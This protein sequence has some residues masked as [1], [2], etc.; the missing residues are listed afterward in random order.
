MVLERVDEHGYGRLRLW[1]SVGFVVVAIGLPL[2]W[3]PGAADEFP[4][5]LAGS[6]GLL[7]LATL[8]FE[9]E[10]RPTHTHGGGAIPGRAW[11]LLAVLALHQVGHG[12]YYAF[13]SI[14]LGDA[15]FDPASIGLLWSL[16]VV[17]EMVAFR[18]GGPLERRLGLRHL[19][20]VALALTPMRWLLLALP[21]TWPVLIVAQ[22]GHALTFAVA[23][24]AGVQLVS[25]WVSP[26]SRRRA[27]ALYSG[28]SFGLGITVGSA[29]AGPVWSRLDAA[30]FGVAAAF[31]V[32]VAVFGWLVVRRDQK[33]TLST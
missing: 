12:P 3:P 11:A 6:L 18:A 20:V 28:L 1:G 15:G 16:G 10:A 19:L 31:A 13:F 32:P 33:I 8:P 4:I 24:L 7:V 2:A 29:L 23:H 14:R 26:G 21:P 30:T 9:G 17:A 5:A 22:A 25:R 27:Q